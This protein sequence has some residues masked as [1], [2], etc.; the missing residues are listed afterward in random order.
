MQEV[1]IRHFSRF[2]RG[3]AFASLACLASCSK[4]EPTKETSAPAP[5][6]STPPAA[7][8]AKPDAPRLEIFID[9]A[10][11]TVFGERFDGALPD[12]KGRLGAALARPHAEGDPTVAATRDAKVPLVATV[13]TALGESKMTGVRVKTVRRDGVTAELPF[14]LGRRRPDCATVGFIG[15]DG[16]IAVWPSSGG[17]A[18]RFSR[19][20]AGPD[21]TRGSEGVKRAMAACESPL[22]AVSADDAVTWGLVADL[23]IA[24]TSAE[25]GAPRARELVLLAHA[26]V[27]GRRVPETD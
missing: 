20:L 6:A 26:P 12:M 9:A 19:G 1:R 17:T 24:V 13:L 16:A 18:Q 11:A 14:A 15:K 7:S 23:V 21:L 22:W 10:S 25:A 4:N 2:C 5:T 3:L 8:A 27:P